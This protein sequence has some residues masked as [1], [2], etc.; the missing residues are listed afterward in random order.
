MFLIERAI[1]YYY[2]V[3]EYSITHAFFIGG[4]YMRQKTSGLTQFKKDIGYHLM[5]W[6]GIIILFIF[7]ILTETSNMAKLNIN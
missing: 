6:P 5:I 3:Q 4:G 1:I 2:K 7:F